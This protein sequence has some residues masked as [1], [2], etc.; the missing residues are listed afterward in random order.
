MNLRSINV[1]GYDTYFAESQDDVG[2]HLLI[3]IP[4]NAGKDISDICG[5]FIDG[6]WIQQ[7]DYQIVDGKVAFIKAYF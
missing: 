4:P 1:N 2:K 5:T 3:A 7:V 6:R